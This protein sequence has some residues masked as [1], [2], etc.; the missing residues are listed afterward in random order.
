M[1]YIGPPEMLNGLG[2]VITLDDTSPVT[3]VISWMVL[4]DNATGI[5]PDGNQTLWYIVEVSNSSSAMLFSTT[6]DHPTN[7]VEA[8]N[9]P[10][11]ENLTVSVTAENLFFSGASAIESFMTVEP[12]W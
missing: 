6:V 8:S 2:V 9:L 4:Q 1:L 11:C 3:A 12:G 5:P 10:A 7:T